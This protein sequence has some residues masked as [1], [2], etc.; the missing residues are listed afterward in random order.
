MFLIIIQPFGRTV[1]VAS[2]AFEKQKRA[3][4]VALFVEAFLWLFYQADSLYW[5]VAEPGASQ[6]VF[7][8]HHAK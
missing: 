6:D 3:R 7:Q 8:T 5:P 4:S 2:V 1:K